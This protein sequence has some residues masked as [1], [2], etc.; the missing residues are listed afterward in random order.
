MVTGVP[1][2]VI[3]ALAD[4][5]LRES[6]TRAIRGEGH[7][8][9]ALVEGSAPGGA[10]DLPALAIVELGI[11]QTEG[12]ELARRLRERWPSMALILVTRDEQ[13]LDAALDLDLRA[14]EYLAKPFSVRELLSRVK[15]LVRRVGL[16]PGAAHAWEDR[17]LTLGPLTVDP[18]RLTA[19]WNG[20]DV[21]VTVTEFF[22]MHALVRRAGV[23]RTREQLMQETFPDH[24]AGSDRIID[25]HMQRIERRFLRLDSRF[26]A[27]EGVHG[28]GYRYRTG[29]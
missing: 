15:A 19:Q 13:A 29:R 23:V 25:A 17:P 4:E 8:A 12:I 11:A 9:V 22:L 7:R 20:R 21:E 18:L 28:A 1:R 14:D 16:I 2:L 6:V 26:D 3:V 10:R 24:A 27:L 5:T